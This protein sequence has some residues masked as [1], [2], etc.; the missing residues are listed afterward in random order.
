MF[1]VRVELRVAVDR[2]HPIVNMNEPLIPH[3]SKFFKRRN[4]RDENNRAG[5]ES[6]FRVRFRPAL[7]A[8]TDDGEG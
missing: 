5:F 3:N 8:R 6:G 4:A 7:N 1:G 2:N